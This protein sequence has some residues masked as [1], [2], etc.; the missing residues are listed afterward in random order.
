MSKKFFDYGNLRKKNQ[1]QKKLKE[2]QKKPILT[3]EE[4]KDLD[5]L[6][7][8]KNANLLYPF[9]MIIDKVTILETIF[10]N[11]PFQHF[12][13]T[14][15]SEKWDF[16]VLNFGYDSEITD[17]PEEINSIYPIISFFKGEKNNAVK[18]SEAILSK[19]GGGGG[20]AGATCPPPRQPTP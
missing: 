14:P 16:M 13:E 4:K 19:G 6:N 11:N 8:Q 3:I 1:Y 2:L 15:H 9:G 18:V 7:F 20:A 10:G 5:I 12:S 17:Y